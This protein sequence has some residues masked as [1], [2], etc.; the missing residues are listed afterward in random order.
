MAREGK[1]YFIE[2]L[3]Y[4][5]LHFCIK[6]KRIKIQNFFKKMISKIP[7]ILFLMFFAQSL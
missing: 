3:F 5:C 1:F 2:I 7:H 4:F 6:I